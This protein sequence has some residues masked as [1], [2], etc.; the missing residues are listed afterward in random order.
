LTSWK[1]V[2]THQHFGG[3]CY[4]HS[5]GKQSQHP[6]ELIYLST[7]THGFTNTLHFR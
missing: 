4:L 6:P 3:I 5:H 2:D 7:T 1:L